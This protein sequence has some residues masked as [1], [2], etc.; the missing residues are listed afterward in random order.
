MSRIYVNDKLIC[1]ISLSKKL[2]IG[3]WKLKLIVN[4]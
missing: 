2:E 4:S 3:K 1:C